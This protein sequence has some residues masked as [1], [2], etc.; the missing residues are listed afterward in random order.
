MV[1]WNKVAWTLAVACV[2]IKWKVDNTHSGQVG[3]MKA[4]F[5]CVCFF[6]VFFL[7]LSWQ[8]HVSKWTRIYIN[9]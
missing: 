6:F 8:C 4:M 1:N 7:T 9:S 2:A 3:M 5:G